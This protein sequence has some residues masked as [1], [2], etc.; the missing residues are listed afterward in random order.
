MTLISTSDAAT[1]SARD[2]LPGLVSKLE[3]NA[4][5]KFEKK[6]VEKGLS[7]QEKDLIYLFRMKIRMTLL[8]W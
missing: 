3:S 5:N 2:N 4:K 1:D 6:I 8:K 7:E